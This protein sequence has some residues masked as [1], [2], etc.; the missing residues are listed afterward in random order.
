[1]Q[2]L[3]KAY[4]SKTLYNTG[5]PNKED[6][7]GSLPDILSCTVDRD[8]EGLFELKISYPRD[9]ANAGALSKLNWLEA[10]AGG[11]MGRQ[12]FQ[13]T[14]IEER[15]DGVLEIAA[16]HRSY[17]LNTML[18]APFST[19]AEA[20]PAFS[21]WKAKL[22]GA[23]KSITTSGYVSVTA[24]EGV[25][26]NPAEY[27]APVTVRKAAFDA[28][29]G[30][31]LH[32]EYTGG[33]LKICKTPE[34]TGDFSIR[35][36]RD[37]AGLRKRTDTGE[38]YTHAFF[39]WRPGGTGYSA[40]SGGIRKLSFVPAALDGVIRIRPVDLTGEYGLEEAG[41]EITNSMTVKWLKANPYDPAPEEISLDAIPMDG[42]RFELGARGTLYYPPSGGGSS[43]IKLPVMIVSLSYDALLGRVTKIGVNKV[44]KDIAYSLAVKNR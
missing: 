28:I 18:A 36:G 22:E 32:M 44:T 41:Q 2:V 3:I 8:T 16:L 29:A 19:G 39:Y 9:G 27:A 38:T 17:N 30:L 1:M 21:V 35:Y 34:G 6:F 14:Q 40:Y 33:G 24:Q 5:S 10:P 20:A 15:M 12:F 26:V 42:N 11:D 37:M 43:M 13:I 23:V 7:L 25:T 4:R 31:S